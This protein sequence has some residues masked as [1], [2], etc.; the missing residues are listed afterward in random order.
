[1][2][3]LYIQQYVQ[4]IPLAPRREITLRVADPP[5][6]YAKSFITAEVEDINGEE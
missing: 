2:Y 1:M 6:D 4:Y 3:V 5:P